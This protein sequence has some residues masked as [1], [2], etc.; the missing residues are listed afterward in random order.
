[1]EE[2]FKYLSLVILIF[3][4]IPGFVWVLLIVS[5]VLKVCG[6]MINAMT[7]K[8]VV[9]YAQQ[10]MTYT[11]IEQDHFGPV[12]DREWREHLDKVLCKGKDERPKTR[13][14]PTVPTVLSEKSEKPLLMGENI[15]HVDFTR[16]DK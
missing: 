11:Y 15:I 13:I 12:D 5:I 1:M 3:A 16:K 4:S 8:Q 6:A 7:H 9:Q 2:V 14:V 10:P